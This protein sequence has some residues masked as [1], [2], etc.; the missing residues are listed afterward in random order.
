MPLSWTIIRVAGSS[1]QMSRKAVR[2]AIGAQSVKIVIYRNG[3]PIFTKELPVGGSLITEEIQRQMAVSYEEAE[4]L[5]TSQGDDGNLPEEVL[6]VIQSQLETHIAEVKK[7]L[8]FYISAGSTEQITECY[9]CGGGSRLA[10]L[11]SMLS[12][13]LGIEVRVFN[14]FEHGLK[15]VGKLAEDQEH[16]GAVGAVAMGL[17][18]R[19]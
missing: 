13:Q 2:G 12:E 6:A 9:L 1:S 10:V 7:N 4:D 14:P 3:G 11:A 15:P 17:A 16:I 19:K 5:K 8:N 18:M